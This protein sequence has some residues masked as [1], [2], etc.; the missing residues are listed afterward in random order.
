MGAD[1]GTD[2]AE[3]HLQLVSIGLKSGLRYVGSA[4]GKDSL[5]PD[6]R[7]YA[8]SGD[9]GPDY[10]LAPVRNSLIAKGMLFSPAYGD[11]AFTVPLFDAFMRRVIPKLI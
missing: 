9:G 5:L 2:L 1:G 11:T 4:T 10:G 8:A 7:D 6:R 3:E